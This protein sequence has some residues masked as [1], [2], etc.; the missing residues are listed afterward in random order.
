[1]DWFILMP[2]IMHLY[3]SS[4]SHDSKNRKR[5]K[6]VRN[7]P[8]CPICGA[9]VHEP[10]KTWV[11]KPKNRRGVI[12]GLFKCPNGHYFRAKVGDAE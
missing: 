8:K 9:E 2:S 6:E 7:M 3:A 12:I 1:M 5:P 10:V 4:P 11:L